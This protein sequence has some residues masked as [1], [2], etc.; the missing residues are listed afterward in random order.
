M[1]T[2]TMNKRGVA[3]TE[4]VVS[5]FILGLVMIALFNLYPTSVLAIKKAEEQLLADNVARSVLERQLAGAFSNL[6]VDTV[7]TLPVVEAENVTF[8]P[9]VSVFAIP[10]REPSLVKRVRVRVFWTTRNEEREVIHETVTSSL[11]N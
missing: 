7:R 1:Y 3:L 2:S 4:L 9:E 10:G 6:Q 11:R 8:T 5:I